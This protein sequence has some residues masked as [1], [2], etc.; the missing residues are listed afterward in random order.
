MKKYNSILLLI[1]VCALIFYPQV[2]VAQ[3]LPSQTYQNGSQPITFE[4]LGYT[5]FTLHSPFDS[6]N[7]RF[8]VPSNWRFASGG[9][10][11]LSYD[12]LLSGPDVYDELG[13]QRE[14][15]GTISVLFNRQ[16]I[17]TLYIEQ[18]GS[19]S[20]SL[21]IPDSA[22]ASLRPDGRHD[23][24]FNL[25]AS[26]SCQYDIRTSVTIKSESYFSLPFETFPPELD[27][28]R[29]PYPYYPVSTFFPGQTTFVIPASP[30]TGELKAAMN[31]FS[32]FGAMTGSSFVYDVVSADELSNELLS[33]SDLIFVGKPDKFSM[34]SEVQFSQ[35][36]S[37]GQFSDLSEANA[38]D[39]IIQIAN[40][41]WNADNA[42]LFVTGETGDAVNKAAQ[43]I[44]TGEIFAAVD[45]K[46]VFVSAVHPYVNSQ[47]VVESFSFRDQGYQTE[48]FNGLGVHYVNISFFLPR[49]QVGSTNASIELKYLSSLFSANRN[50]SIAVNLN[51]SLVAALDIVS[52]SENLQTSKISI[53]PGLLKFGENRLEIQISLLPAFSCD[54]GRLQDNFVTLLDESIINIPVP[55]A[56]ISKSLSVDLGFY[57]DIFLQTSDLSDVTF[58]LPQDNLTSWKVASQV[59]LALGRIASPSLS[60]FDVVFGNDVPQETLKKQNLMIVG[61][62]ST[63]PIL[64]ELND[65]LPA[66][67]DFES[68]TA[69]EEGLQISYRTPP[70]TD[71]GYLE[72]LNSPYNQNK[73]IL[74]VS[75]S[76]DDGVGL[77]GNV[78][79]LSEFKSSLA[80][81]FAVTNG[82]QVVTTR[83][84]TSLGLGV[85]MGSV[86]G[87]IVPDAEKIVN[88]PVPAGLSQNNDSNT[89]PVW[90]VPVFVVSG[91]LVIFLLIRNLINSGKSNRRPSTDMDNADGK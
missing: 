54:P 25:L 40:S 32:G 89:P 56:Q 15:G 47:A 35:P 18:S 43:A 60:T 34:L 45:P 39:G 10:I 73:V 38:E 82:N 24:E 1:L 7:V 21:T 33:S 28:A 55:P 23:L 70:G 14:F 30:E 91:I 85:S 29:L 72:L 3:T 78:I 2:V 83:A 31:L 5:D 62:A 58:V 76:T 48:T 41:P 53:P 44:S 36:V 13:R 26:E 65:M 52:Q 67:F 69:S 77:A 79:T 71:L 9:E 81:Q 49:E 90:L 12:V 64:S 16:L 6:N 50:T 51:G 8:S 37:N 46:L 84:K 19:F 22:L 20:L 88:T 66:P 17:D 59:A 80:G 4:E 68:D 87:T 11:Y 61:R 74:I 57:P 86:V 63:L 27:L 42:V 75:G